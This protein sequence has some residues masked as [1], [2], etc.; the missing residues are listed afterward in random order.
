MSRKF[1]THHYFKVKLAFSTAILVVLFLG[2]FAVF[3]HH[4]LEGFISSLEETDSIIQE[5]RGIK[6]VVGD[7]QLGVRG[8][9]ITGDSNFLATYTEAID[10]SE[11]H[12]QKLE[13]A[14]TTSASKYR[15]VTSLKATLDAI[16]QD[17]AQVVA[18]KNN[19]NNEEANQK[20]A[21]SKTSENLATV[22]RIL[23]D[24][25]REEVNA[26]QMRLLDLD[27]SIT[28]QRNILYL[29][30]GIGIVLILLA[31]LFVMRTLKQKDRAEAELN[32]FF[33]SSPDM[34]CIVGLDTS[35]KRINPVFENLLGYTLE[36]IM[37]KSFLELIHPEDRESTINELSQLK[38]TLKPMSFEN[39]YLCK[40]GTFKWF[41]WKT[42]IV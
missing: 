16:F 33:A 30:F 3:G 35:F 10:V 13:R 18:L 20:F 40:D 27:N 39:R 38:T 31:G 32:R 2:V 42:T 26:Q 28:Q 19:G 24:L 25:E 22:K 21:S 8:Y 7:V 34:F 12:L 1:F 5:V 41:S 14:T 23:Y 4:R 11:S 37:T 6:K 9:L 36:E 17:N 15:R 29:G